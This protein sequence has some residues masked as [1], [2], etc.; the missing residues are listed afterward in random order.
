MF[1]QLRLNKAMAG[2]RLHGRRDTIFCDLWRSG[3]VRGLSQPPT[4]PMIRWR[5]CCIEFFAAPES[6]VLAGIAK[7]QA[8]YAA[9]IALV[10]PMLEFERHDVLEYLAA[11]EQDYRTDATNREHS[12]DAQSVAT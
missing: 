11:I 7:V 3:S 9:S 2:K 8:A 12:M 10:R 5:R 1:R 4:R 6:R